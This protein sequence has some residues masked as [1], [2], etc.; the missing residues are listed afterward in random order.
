MEGKIN[1]MTDELKG[2]S[3]ELIT[4]EHPKSPVAEAYRSIRTSLKY[5][6]PD[7][8][9]KSIMVTSSGAGEGKSFII[10]NLAVA[11][12]QND[13]KII[14]IDADL[15]KPMQHRFYD[16]TNFEGLSSVLTGE[17]SFTEAKRETNIDNIQL[18]STGVIPP[19][20]AELL[21]SKKMQEVINKAKEEAD[22]VLIDSPPIIPVTDAMLL[23]KSVDGVLLVV[24][25]HETEREM[26]V[27]AKE[28]LDRVDANIL[29]TVLNK[30]PTDQKGKYYNQYYYYYSSDQST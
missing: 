14:I 11:M 8:P 16:M 12:A 27:K 3:N 5:L 13:N 23:S 10:S 24:A 26:L 6:S 19:N 9:L 17:I 2:R 21:D 29:G 20:P 30:Y 7:K 28:Q 22:I 18:I 25:S 15:R 1:K 4:R